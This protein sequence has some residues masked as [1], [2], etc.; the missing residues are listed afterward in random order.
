MDKPT[1]NAPCRRR[2]MKA[3]MTKGTTTNPLPPAVPRSPAT[4]E[5]DAS[6]ARSHQFW[7]LRGG[8]LRVL[9]GHRGPRGPLS[10]SSPSS[11]CRSCYRSSLPSFR[12]L[13]LGR[14]ARLSTKLL[15]RPSTTPYHSSYL[16]SRTLFHDITLC[17][18]SPPSPLSYH[19]F[20][21]RV[22]QDISQ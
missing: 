3:K 14:H 8:V 17:S 10:T 4:A 18:P 12:C 22:I 15:F 13:C 5:A 2:W 16:C 6:V 7:R 21:Y 9:S 1:F 20:L 19:P 11:S